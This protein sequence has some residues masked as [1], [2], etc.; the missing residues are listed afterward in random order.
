MVRHIAL[1]R[2]TDRHGLTL[3]DVTPWHH[4]LCPGGAQQLCHG[5]WKQPAPKWWLTVWGM[6]VGFRGGLYPWHVDQWGVRCCTVANNAGAPISSLGR[7]CRQR[8]QHTQECGMPVIPK[9]CERGGINIQQCVCTYVY[10]GNF[11]VLVFEKCLEICR[12]YSHF[13]SVQCCS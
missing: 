9:A 12:C 2:A 6:H 7:V 4:D 10:D 8:N 3:L 13:E 5:H 11:L 1:V